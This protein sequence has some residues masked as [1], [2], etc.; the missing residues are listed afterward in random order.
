VARNCINPI[1]S[2]VGMHSRSGVLGTDLRSMKT[3]EKMRKKDARIY[4]VS[5]LRAHLASV[6]RHRARY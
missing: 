6:M 1:T 5:I 4:L 2:Q 3:S